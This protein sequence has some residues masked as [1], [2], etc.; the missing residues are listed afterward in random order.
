MIPSR[1]ALILGAG[2][3][4]LAATARADAPNDGL[5]LTG[6]FVQGGFVMG[7]TWPRAL[8][9]VDGEALTT[10]SAAGLF[11]VGFDRDAPGTLQL[12]A[13]DRTRSARRSLTIVPGQ[14]ASTRIDGLPPSTVEPTDPALL[15]RIQQEAA[16]KAEGFASRAD[17]DD[18]RS[19]F[20]WPLDTWRVTSAWGAQR[21]LNGTPARPHYGIDLA[22]PAGTPIL[23]PADGIVTLARTSLH[24]EGGL[25]L[26]DH[27][28]GLVTACL[29]QSRINVLPNQRV[30]RGDVIGRVGM[31]GRATGPHLCWRMRWRDR[32]LD[33]SLMI[34]QSAPETALATGQAFRAM[35]PPVF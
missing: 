35:D 6:R 32:N 7:R 1:R 27:G 29:H 31:T 16:L 34:G 28:Q 30:T 20:V 2:A 13:R 5:A 11:I 4:S 26:I 10:A 22:A 8:V 24:F 23:A 3:A 12:E 33:P 18:F 15:A 19:G 21:V 14:F 17:A 9:F 25:T